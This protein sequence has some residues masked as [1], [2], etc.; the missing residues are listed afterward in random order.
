MSYVPEVINGISESVVLVSADNFLMAKSDPALLVS[1]GR[2]W[3]TAPASSSPSKLTSSC[4]KN[5]K[6]LFKGV[7]E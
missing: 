4:K 7:W 5:Y 1:L 6:S 3:L 2:I